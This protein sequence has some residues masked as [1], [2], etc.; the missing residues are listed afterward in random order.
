MLAFTQCIIAV[1]YTHLAAGI[2]IRLVN[3]TVSDAELIL[4]VDIQDGGVADIQIAAVSGSDRALVVG[5]VMY[6]GEYHAVGAVSYTHR[7]MNEPI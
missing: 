7:R 2:L 5:N 6:C 3:R 1:S 4:G